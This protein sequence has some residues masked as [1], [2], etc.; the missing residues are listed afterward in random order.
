MTKN[1]LYSHHI[2]WGH[3]KPPLPP[4]P[5]VPILK[6]GSK[7]MTARMVKKYREEQHDYIII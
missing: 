4:P 1:H 6:Q 3:C 7:E 5:V 2:P